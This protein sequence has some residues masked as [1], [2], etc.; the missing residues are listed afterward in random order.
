VRH[1]NAYICIA[2]LVNN[3]HCSKTAVHINKVWSVELEPCF[4]LSL[5]QQ[6]TQRTAHILELVL[7]EVQMVC[8]FDSEADSFSCQAFRFCSVGFF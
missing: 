4:I 5:Q 2:D 6:L 1:R 7:S 3:G 8:M